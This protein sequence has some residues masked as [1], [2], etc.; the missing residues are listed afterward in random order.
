MLKKVVIAFIVIVMLTHPLLAG[1]GP[2]GPLCDPFRPSVTNHIWFWWP[3]GIAGFEFDDSGNL[4]YIVDG[5]PSQY[6]ELISSSVQKEF[7]KLP[8]SGEFT[9][10]HPI[11]KGGLGG[12]WLKHYAV[13]SIIQP[14]GTVTPGV[15]YKYERD[16]GNHITEAIKEDFT[17]F[18]DQP[19]DS[20]LA[21]YVWKIDNNELY[22]IAFDK[23]GFTRYL[24]HGIPG[25]YSLNDVPSPEYCVWYPLSATSKNGYWLKHTAIKEFRMA[26]GTVTP[27]VDRRFTA[28]YNLTDLTKNHAPTYTDQPFNPPLENHIWKKDKNNLRGF[29]F[30]E[31]G[32]LLYMIDGVYGTYSLDDVP[33][34]GEYT[35]WYPITPVSLYGYWLK[36][37]AVTDIES[38]NTAP[39][40]DYTYKAGKSIIDLPKSSEYTFEWSTLQNHIWKRKGDELYGAQYDEKGDLLYLIHGVPGTYSLNHVPLSGEYVVWFPLEKEE[41]YWLKYTAVTEGEMEWGP[42]TFGVDLLYYQKEGHGISFLTRD[43]YSEDWDVRKLL[44][45]FWDLFNQ[46]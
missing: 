7:Q 8:F 29:E 41:G 35:V 12:F 3:E 24:V 25:T 34:S 31:K 16:G 6:G 23:K 40:I 22:G 9:Y 38:S 44:K 42:I 4:L 13:K 36:Y 43:H 2:R 5:I 27:G 18:K 20:P 30:D 21:N 14:W 15:D 33:Y 26:W 45:Y 1:E 11:K 32:N 17:Y 37:T 28:Q 19:F 46:S 10:W 39:G